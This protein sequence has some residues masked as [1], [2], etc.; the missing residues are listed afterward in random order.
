MVSGLLSYKLLESM[1]RQF[2]PSPQVF[3]PR[4]SFTCSGKIESW[5]LGGALLGE[6]GRF[7]LHHWRRIE[8]SVSRVEFTSIEADDIQSTRYPN[9]YRISTTASQFAFNSSD[10]VDIT[11]PSD[12]DVEPFTLYATNLRDNEILHNA[13]VQENSLSGFVVGFPLLSLEVSGII[14]ISEGQLM[15]LKHA[16]AVWVVG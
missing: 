9:V 6:K 16:M 7:T 1:F 8:S 12:Q 13:I 3:G 2:L 4:T 11:Y 15:F 14:T 10:Y 5:L